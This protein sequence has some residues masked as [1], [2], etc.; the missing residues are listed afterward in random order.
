MDVECRFWEHLQLNFAQVCLASLTPWV[1]DFAF[2]V[3]EAGYEVVE[4]TETVL[5]QKLLE[6]VVGGEVSEFEGQA[7]WAF[8]PLRRCIQPTQSNCPR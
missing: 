4:A 3:G 5:G 6:E 1:G 2:I 7:A 8:L